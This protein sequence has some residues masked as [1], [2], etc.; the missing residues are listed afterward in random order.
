MSNYHKAIIAVI[1]ANF[2]FGTTIIAVKHITPTLISPIALTSVRIVTTAILFWTFFGFNKNNKPFNSK[3]FYK[4]IGSSILG[5]SLN[6][7][8]SIKGM[9]LTSPIHASLLILTTPI[10][11]TLLAAILIK[12]KLT[13]YKILGLLL[14]LSGGAL[15]IFSRDLSVINKGDQTT[16]DLFVIMGAI[17]Y[18]IYVVMMRSLASQYA[19]L[20]ILKWVFLIGA[21]I[22]L[23]LGW[24]D[25]QKVD[26][27]AFDGLSWF[28]LSY[29]VIGATFLSYLFINYSISNIGATLTGAFMYSQPVFAAISGMI[30]L[31]EGLSFPKIASASLIM[32]GVYLANI[33][34][35]PSWFNSEK[36]N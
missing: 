7:A 1:L 34:K 27:H 24:H 28:C 9:S 5:I 6:Q 25:L 15:L 32:S 35:Y 4:L 21:F 14:G 11:I 20:S 30:F 8:F 26:W 16:G 12:E 13:I 3:D 10:T 22:N 18:S 31:G 23:P 29:V 2:F 17:C 33:S 36:I 19:N